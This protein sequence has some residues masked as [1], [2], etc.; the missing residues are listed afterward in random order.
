[1]SVSEVLGLRPESMLGAC[2]SGCV[3]ADLTV[4]SNSCNSGKIFCHYSFN[5]TIGSVMSI[6][7]VSHEIEGPFCYSSLSSPYFHESR[8]QPV[9]GSW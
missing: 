3:R 9:G 8:S 2:R 1:V 6:H 4:M 7:I 5:C